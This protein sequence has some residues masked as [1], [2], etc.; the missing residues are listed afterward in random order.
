LTNWQLISNVRGESLFSDLS[1]I[2]EYSKCDYSDSSALLVSQCESS[3]VY[4]QSLLT[5]IR[6]FGISHIDV[7]FFGYILMAITLICVIELFRLI[8]PFPSLKQ[9]IV[10]ILYLASPPLVLLFERGNLDSLVFVLTVFS[11]SLFLKKHTLLSQL[12]IFLATIVKFYPIPVL[13]VNYKLS[14]SKIE[15]TGSFILLTL[16]I[17]FIILFLFSVNLHSIP[18]P[19]RVAFGSSLIGKSI[20]QLFGTDITR[21]WQLLIGLLSLMSSFFFLT[22][23]S[24][25]YHWFTEYKFK[26]LSMND[27][28]KYILYVYSSIYFFTFFL[29]MNFDYRLIFLL[30]IFYILLSIELKHKIFFVVI[31]ILSLWF[32]F[33]VYSLEILGDFFLFLFTFVYFFLVLPNYRTF[34][35]FFNKKI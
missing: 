12:P 2:L 22:I 24:R 17:L 27:T 5:F 19:T 13:Y 32:S 29:S 33:Q 30:P 3:F 4:G 21:V 25:K 10:A 6:F 1:L 34:R 7:N 28:P 14:K 31:S 8:K 26:L 16:S 9:E 15:K 35:N 11:V 20:N 23:I 18:N